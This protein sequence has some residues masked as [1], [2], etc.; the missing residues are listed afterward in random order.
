MPFSFQEDKIRNAY[1]RIKGQNS[2]GKLTLSEKTA[3]YFL[4]LFKAKSMYPEI[5]DLC[6][7]YPKLT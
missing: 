3:E 5:I 6:E 4:F 7:N 1:I 2:S